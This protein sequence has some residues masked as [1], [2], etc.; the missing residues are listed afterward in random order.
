MAWSEKRDGPEDHEIWDL[1]TTFVDPA[2]MATDPVLRLSEE[3]VDQ[4]DGIVLYQSM[5]PT[6]VCAAY[7][8]GATY[9][10]RLNDGFDNTPKFI[11]FLWRR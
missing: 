11:P 9:L 7:G 10:Y 6:I 8:C 4:V 5:D 2:G 3:T 1:V